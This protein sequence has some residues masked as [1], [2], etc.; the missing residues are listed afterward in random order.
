[1]AESRFTSGA[2]HVVVYALSDAGVGLSKRACGATRGCYFVFVMFT[3]DTALCVLLQLG[4]EPPTAE[5]PHAV[6]GRYGVYS[7]C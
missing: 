6:R 4:C 1:M 3:F 2:P 7:I 5:N